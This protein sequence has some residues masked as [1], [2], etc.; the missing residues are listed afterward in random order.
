LTEKAP[1]LGV[2]VPK[3]TPKKGVKNGSKMGQKWVILDPLRG[4]GAKVPFLPK[5]AI[6]AKS[7]K[8]VF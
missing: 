2:F 1:F 7:E 3:M 6:F 4:R 5:M 8:V